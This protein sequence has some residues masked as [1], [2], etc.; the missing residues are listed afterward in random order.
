MNSKGILPRLPLSIQ[1]EI[2]E[3]AEAALKVPSEFIDS[4]TTLAFDAV[5]TGILNNTPL[6]PSRLL[7]PMLVH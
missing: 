3:S 2:P 7:A 1:T 5:P 6:E 4:A